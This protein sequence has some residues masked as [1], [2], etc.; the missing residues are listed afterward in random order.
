V[1]NTMIKERRRCVGEEVGDYDK[2]KASVLML[3]FEGMCR[4]VVW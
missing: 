4:R 3:L 1:T 2:G